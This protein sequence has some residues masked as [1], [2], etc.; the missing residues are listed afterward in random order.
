MQG[1][2]PSESF[3]KWGQVLQSYLTHALATD[4]AAFVVQ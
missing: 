4:A 2:Q 3:F 1:A